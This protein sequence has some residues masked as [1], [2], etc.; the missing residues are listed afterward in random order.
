LVLPSGLRE[1]IRTT[2]VPKYRTLGSTVRFTVVE[3]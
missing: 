2:G 3:R 1:L